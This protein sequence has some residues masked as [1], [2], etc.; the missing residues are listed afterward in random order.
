L[1]ARHPKTP[2]PIFTKIGRRD[3]VLDVTRHAKFC[4][5]LFR[6]FC[7]QIRHFAVP[8][9]VTSFYV[10]FLGWG[11]FNKATAYTLNAF[12]RKTRQMTSLRVPKCLF[13]FPMTIFFII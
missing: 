11:F 12:L 5:N 7:S 13:A 10:R 8:F 2:L 6:Y 3:Y 1:T 9:D 4:N